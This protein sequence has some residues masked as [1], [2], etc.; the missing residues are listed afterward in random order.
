MENFSY[1]VPFYVV[2]GGIATSG[3]SSDLQGG[4]VGLFDRQTFSVA[5][6]IGSGKEFFFAQGP[7]GGKDWYGQPAEGSHKSPF[8]FVKDVENMYLSKP[9]TIQNEEWVIGF[10]GSTSSKGLTFET[11]KAIRVQL[12][13]H[14]E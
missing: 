3:H 14:G 6:G 12:F 4:K 10:N 1:H 9:Q 5:T 11:G 13:F 2:T 8:F 7:I